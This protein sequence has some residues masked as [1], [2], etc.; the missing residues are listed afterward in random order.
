M[1]SYNSFKVAQQQILEAAKLLNLDKATKDLLAW[2]Q[3]EINF[4]LHVKMDNGK[5]KIF[6]A[7]RIQ[8][9]YAEGQLKAE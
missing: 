6:H 4:S 5:V 8:Y 2:P 9:N 3:R 1:E 7:Y